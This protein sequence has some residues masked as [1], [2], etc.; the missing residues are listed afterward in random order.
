MKN[1]K[2]KNYTYTGLGFPVELKNITML[3]IEGEWCPKIDVRLISDIV[4]KSLPFQKE[5]LT[6]NQIKFIRSYFEM[7]LRE[8]SNSV[9]SVSHTA[10]SKWENCTESATNMDTSIEIILRLYVYEQTSINTK[11]E[12]LE[13]FEKYLALREMKFLSSTPK[14][15]LMDVA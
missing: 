4:I 9:V 15:I 14:V 6:G 11:K 1:K 5:R 13:F 10:V 3:F 8:F 12:K 7:S 2:I